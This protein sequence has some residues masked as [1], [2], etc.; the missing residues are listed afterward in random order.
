MWLIIL[1][2]AIATFN[3]LDLY[4]GHLEKMK[5]LEKDKCQ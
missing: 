5:E 1:I 3:C 4:F 2:L